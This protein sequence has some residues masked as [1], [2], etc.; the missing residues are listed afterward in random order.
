[1]V[2]TSPDEVR[3]EVTSPPDVRFGQA[4][5]ATASCM[6]NMQVSVITAAMERKRL[7][8][9]I[10]ADRVVTHGS[11]L[12]AM[13]SNVL[14]NRGRRLAATTHQLALNETADAMRLRL[15]RQMEQV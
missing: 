12:L 9:V 4:Y 15:K 6:K 7:D 14:A 8:V 5:A 3:L 10:M 11:N 2:T 1:M 13:V